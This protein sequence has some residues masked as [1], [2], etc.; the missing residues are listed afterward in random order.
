MYKS[1]RKSELIRL[2]LA[3]DVQVRQRGAWGHIGQARPKAPSGAAISIKAADAAALALEV[4]LAEARAGD[5]DLPDKAD[6]ARHEA[7]LVELWA[8]VAAAAAAVATALEEEA[9]AGADPVDD[10]DPVFDDE[11][12]VLPAAEVAACAA[13][14][15]EVVAEA[16]AEEERDFASEAEA[17]ERADAEDEGAVALI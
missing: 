14:F 1:H 7:A 5:E 8:R 4:A 3:S 16:A 9:A 13:A 6:A 12:T 2:G 10:D 11:L 15:A 17:R